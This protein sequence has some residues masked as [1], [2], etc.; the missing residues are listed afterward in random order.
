MLLAG[1]PGC[2]K[3]MVARAVAG[4]WHVALAA[5]DVGRLHGSLVGESESRLREALAASVAMAP[6]VLWIDEVEKA[7]AESG[8]SDG[9][10]SQRVLGVLLRWLQD[11][12]D[13]V[14][15]VA[16][17]NDVTKL[18]P[19]V[20]RRGR[21]DELFFVDL[22]DLL[23]RRT[24]LAHHLR[25]RRRDPAAFDLDALAVTSGGFSGAELESAVTAAL[26]TAYSRGCDIDTAALLAEL[27][28]TVP[29]SVTRAEDV[30]ALRLWAKGRARPAGGSP[31]PRVPV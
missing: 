8:E 9:G 30:A 4:S 7:F 20:T 3:S 2:G 11:R 19:E 22:P 26:Y 10:V 15:L 6:V 31:P 12:P 14:F 29:L 5:L 13:G 21:F 27:R 23:E 25:T 1:V 24:I 28:R 18:P 17:C 16:T